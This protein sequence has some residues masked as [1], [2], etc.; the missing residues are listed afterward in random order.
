MAAVESWAE[1]NPGTVRKYNEDNL[2]ARPELGLWAVADGAGGHHRGDL[3]SSMIVE[4]LAQIPQGLGFDD[5]TDA[6]R[7]SISATHRAL[8]AAARARGPN[9]VIAST[10]VGMI[11][12]ADKFCCLWAGD[13]R[14]YLLRNGE[15]LQISRDHSLVQEL[16]DLGKINLEDAEHH[17]QAN[18][19]TRAIGGD[20]DDIVL[21]AIIGT[22]KP[23]DLFLLCSDG[24]SKTM[25]LAE[26]SRF[27]QQPERSL[28]A[29]KLVAAAIDHGGRDNITVLV[30][31]VP[32]S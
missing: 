24:L 9:V 8:R 15:V 31:S 28:M 29:Q 11:I 4:A 13:S 30:I 27:L 3:A 21:D 26:I 7:A 23:D 12:H 2:L 5:L 16:V 14:A 32:E 1:T 19:I 6:V 22:A 25:P 17:P 18:I 20:Q 10:F